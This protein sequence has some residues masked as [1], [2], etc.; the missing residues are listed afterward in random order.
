M[1]IVLR[2]SSLVFNMKCPTLNYLFSVISFLHNATFFLQEKVRNR[3]VSGEKAYLW[4]V[5]LE[6]LLNSFMKI[7]FQCNNFISASK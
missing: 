3:F 1:V 2:V 4:R 5:G 6:V 7:F